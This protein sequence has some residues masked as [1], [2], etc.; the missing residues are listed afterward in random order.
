LLF[1]SGA[2]ALLVSRGGLGVFDDFETELFDDRIGEDLAC[3]L[4]DF[5]SSGGAIHTLEIEDE[6]FA[7]ADIAHGGVAE[8]R[9]G[10]LDGGALRI[11]HGAF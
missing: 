4:L 6:K 1:T 2:D 8:G 5:G 9:Q 7:L 10:V 11:E 3:D